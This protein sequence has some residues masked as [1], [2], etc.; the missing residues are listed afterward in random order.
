[1]ELF[2]RA[3]PR[4]YLRQIKRVRTSVIALIPPVRGIRA[5]LAASGS[6]TGSISD[7]MS[8][9]KSPVAFEGVVKATSSGSR[10]IGTSAK[11]SPLTTTIASRGLDGSDWLSEGRRK[12]IFR[13]VCVVARRAPRS[14]EAVLRAGGAAVAEVRVYQPR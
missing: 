2:D 7:C 1:M 4:H 11:V 6:S 10:V 5:T 3:F 14:W 12:D 8:S 9:S 13:A